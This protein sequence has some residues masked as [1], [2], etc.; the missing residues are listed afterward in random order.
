LKITKNLWEVVEEAT[1]RKGI[2]LGNQSRAFKPTRNWSRRN[3]Q[4]SKV[5]NEIAQ[6]E[7]LEDHTEYHGRSLR[8]HWKRWDWKRTRMPWELCNGKPKDR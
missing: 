7:Q 4:T 8:I 2:E 1:N 6:K 5:E 3:A